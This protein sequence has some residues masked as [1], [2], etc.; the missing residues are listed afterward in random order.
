MSGV[1]A[2]LIATGSG[3]LNPAIAAAIGAG[4]AVLGALL[5]GLANV[6]GSHLVTKR[7]SD[8]EA[9]AAA[10]VVLMELLTVSAQLRAL[11][12]HRLPLSQITPIKITD[13]V[14]QRHTL[15]GRITDATEWARYA[16]W[17]AFATRVNEKAASGH[18]GSDDQA[19]IGHLIESVKEAV[20]A[21]NTAAESE[22][23]IDSVLKGLDEEQAADTA[24]SSPVGDGGSDQ[25]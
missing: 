21:V 3:G 25:Q 4:G 12:I 13:A 15:A 20:G 10:R 16:G 17:V 2:L 11:R 18:L 1:P 19:T 5:G 7:R 9:K 22:L 14:E 6:V 24:E 23:N 8:Y